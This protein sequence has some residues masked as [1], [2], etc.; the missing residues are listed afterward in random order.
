MLKSL[1]R[2]FI[3]L[4]KE[5]IRK[6]F[7]SLKKTSLNVTLEIPKDKEHGNLTSNIALKLSSILRKNPFD[8]A[9]IIKKGIL[10]QLK[11][12]KL[13][14][15]IASIEI[16]NPGFINFYLSE[17]FLFQLLK[18]IINT[19][20]KFKPTTLGKGKRIQIEFVSANPTGPLSIAHGRQ[21]AVGDT[22]ANI[23]ELCGY[24]VI[25][26]YF[27]NDEGNQIDAL[28]KSV[29]AKYLQLHNNKSSLPKDGYQGEYVIDIAKEFDKKFGDRFIDSKK[30]HN[31]LNMIS[32]F[33]INRILSGIKDDLDNFGVHMDVWFS[34]KALSKNGQID[35]IIKEF[36]DKGLVYEKDKALWF[37]ATEFGDDKDRVVVKSNGEY[38]YLAPDAAYHKDKY[39]RKFNKVINIWGP[40]HHG[41]IK[42]LKAAVSALGC[43][44][45]FIEVLIIQLASLYR[46]GK[47][48]PM[49]T[50]KG[51]YITLAELANEIGVDAARFFFLM[52]KTNTHLD[53][54]IELAKKKSLDNPV[55]YIQYAHARICSIIENQRKIR[56]RFKQSDYS[57][58][59]T[60]EEKEVIRSLIEF[61]HIVELA[62]LNLEP[63]FLTMYLRQLAD[64]FH[65]FYQKYRVLGEDSALTAARLKLIQAVKNVLSKGL[66]ILG[67]S[68]PTKM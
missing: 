37:R 24:K 19:P 5:S 34:Q 8:I 33:S 51:E 32:T 56:K 48:I 62:A 45:G 39:K 20:K 3:Q 42:R 18:I 63:Y 58:L 55:Y 1:E 13:R 50:R 2:E 12:T 40:D 4:I 67:V 64:S 17:D 6:N 21:A 57:L 23:M 22:L 49:S 7:P 68:T 61:P 44:D 47:P 59:N 25:R 10:K 9:E 14:R 41:Y 36:K 28:A 31:L 43:P 38:T 54:D 65:S 53:L 29:Y 35:K 46:K 11:G 27:I 30:E 52:R 60:P 16:K 26:E 15:Q 66:N